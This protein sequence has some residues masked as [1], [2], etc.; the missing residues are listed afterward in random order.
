[1]MTSNRIKTAFALA[2][3]VITGFA[4]NVAAE[5]MPPKPDGRPVDAAKPLKVFILVGQSNMQ[6]H[7][8]IS[9]F[10]PM[11]LDPKIQQKLR[12]LQE[13]GKLNRDE[14]QAAL[15]KQRAEAFAPREMEILT[16][17]VSNFE[18]HYLGSARTMARI[19]K[20]FAEA[21]VEM[22]DK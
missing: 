5:D 7:A 9:T 1:M 6:G 20:G 4:F 15:E 11:R 19:G 18:F 8:N 17:S 12:E 3:V 21:L 10:D 14:A 16:K 2:A 22:M 13:E